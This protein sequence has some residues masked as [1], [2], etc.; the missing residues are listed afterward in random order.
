M[1]TPAEENHV[2]DLGRLDGPVLCFGGPYSNA[3]ATEAMLAEARTRGIPSERVICT[4]D[5]VAYGGDPQAC[6]DLVR[7]AGI[8]VVMG[9][10]EESLGFN[11]ADCNCGFEKDSDCAAWSTDWFT[12]AA[13]VLDGDALAWMRALPRQLRF[14][15][16]GRNIAVIHGGDQNISEYV[17]ASTPDAAK[18]EIIDRLDADAVIGGHSGLPFTQV[19]GPRVLNTQNIGGR[20][21]HNPGAIGMPANDATPRGWYSIISGHADGVDIAL[22]GLDY[23][24]HAAARAIRAYSPDLPYAQTL[25][26]GLWPNMAVL[27]ETERRFQGLALDPPTV[28]W[29]NLHTAAAE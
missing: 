9:N 22:Y 16:A 19:L 11:A 15:M 10:C 17:F 7:E 8:R 21:W 13:A 12:H 2:L 4:G 28:H 26:D 20:L 14:T 18:A 29:P 6:I 3:Q 23:D 1:T 5:V 24:H 27:P 25:E